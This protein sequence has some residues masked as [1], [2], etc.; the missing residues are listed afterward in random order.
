[1]YI[2]RNGLPFWGRVLLES[3]HLCITFDQH[4]ITQ[5]LSALR[6]AGRGARWLGSTF[7][8]ICWGMFLFSVTL[9]SIWSLAYH[10]SNS[11]INRYVNKEARTECPNLVPE[12]SA[13]RCRFSCGSLPD[14]SDGLKMPEKLFNQWFWSYLMAWQHC[15]LVLSLFSFRVLISIFVSL[16]L[17][18]GSKSMP[19][20]PTGDQF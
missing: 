8:S 4:L 3:S 11:H 14:L 5:S 12:P 1:M 17:V 7:L 10:F 13:R 2:F 9:V 19:K 20:C 6:R 18:F 16:L 15:L